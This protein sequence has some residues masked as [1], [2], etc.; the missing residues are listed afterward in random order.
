MARRTKREMEKMNNF[1]RLYLL[2]NKLDPHAAHEEMVKE[3]L[4]SGTMIPYYIKGVKDFIQ[5]SQELAVELNRKEQMK[6]ADKERFEAKETIARFILKLT[7]EE[8]YS[9]YKE[10]K[11]KV[12]NSHKLVL[13]DVYHLKA[14]EDFKNEY[15]DQQMINAFTQI[16]RDQLQTA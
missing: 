3:H 8:V 4:T 13:I 11:D 2:S 10:Y 16:Y 5:V 6:K 9:L 14:A 15:I 1:C 12:S 7:K